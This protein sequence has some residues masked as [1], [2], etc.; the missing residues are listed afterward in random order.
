MSTVEER[1]LITMVEIISHTNSH[2]KLKFLV[3]RSGEAERSIAEYEELLNN[4]ETLK[5]YLDYL[6]VSNKRKYNA[7]ISKKPMLIEVYSKHEEHER[8]I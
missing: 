3:K 1:F 7:L 6:R 4:T 8:D 2:G 5:K